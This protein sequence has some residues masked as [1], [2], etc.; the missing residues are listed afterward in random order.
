M[1]DEEIADLL[2]DADT[3]RERAHLLV[4]LQMSQSLTSI[5]SAFE[6]HRSEFQQHREEFETH[7]EVFARTNNRLSGAWMATSII[8]SVVMAVVGWYVAHHV[9]DVNERQQVQIDAISNRTTAVETRIHALTDQ[10]REK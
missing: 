9:V 7:V 3:P 5:A 1:S 2:R 8:L 6:A 4:L 10:L